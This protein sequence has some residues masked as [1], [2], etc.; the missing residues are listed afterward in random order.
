MSY[1][2]ALE[3]VHPEV[4]KKVIFTHHFPSP[5]G[6]ELLHRLLTTLYFY[7]SMSGRLVEWILAGALLADGSK[8][9]QQK[10]PVT[11]YSCDKILS[12]YV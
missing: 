1:E 12:D 11:C 9:P 6:Q 5:T 8:S 3:N 2:G 4:H 10:F 7:A